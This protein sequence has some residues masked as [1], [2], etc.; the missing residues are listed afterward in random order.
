MSKNFDNLIQEIYHNEE[1]APDVMGNIYEKRTAWYVF[2]NR[3]FIQRYKL[4]GAALLLVFTAGLLWFV[5]SPSQK[6]VEMTVTPIQVES[7]PSD[8]TAGIV[9][10][11]AEA[12]DNMKEKSNDQAVDPV[13]AEDH[14]RPNTPSNSP[15]E[16]EAPIQVDD[17]SVSDVMRR[18][19]QRMRD[20][21]SDGANSM[22]NSNLGSAG[23]GKSAGDG[24]GDKQADK[25]E[26]IATNP[27]TPVDL[28]DTKLTNDPP[29]EDDERQIVTADEADKK[30]NEPAETKKDQE[31]Q[32]NNDQILPEH[33]PIRKWSLS[34]G[35]G[36]SSA[37]RKLDQN[38][39]ME[40]ANLRDRSESKF[41]SHEAFINFNLE[42]GQHVELYTGI[43]YLNRRER[44]EFT[45]VENYTIRNITENEV[46]AVHPLLPPRTFI[47]F[48]T[49]YTQIS[50][51]KNLQSTN[52]YT[53]YTLP[54]GLRYTWYQ[55]K[56]GV[57]ASADA[58]IQL[59]AQNNG[60]ILTV[61][62]VEQDLSSSDFNRRKK[63][64]AT[65]GGSFGVSY[66]FDERIT[67]LIGWKGT[68][69]LT[70]VNGS[71][72]LLDQRDYSSSLMVGVKYHF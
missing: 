28:E 58:A 16:Y 71:R 40:L 7:S 50:T 38:Q 62:A 54:I 64:G 5:W 46:V 3:L 51:S 31:D 23:D 22:G 30:A 60:S 55:N 39:N 47:L 6:E 1:S 36:A 11:D 49:S 37:Y 10:N 69:F 63:L 42:L 72:Y 53:Y 44:M 9:K 13:A 25:V 70:P 32:L 14:I 17:I 56:L 43:N 27:A 52:T 65:A 4:S 57:Y 8:N 18:R 45:S 2:R 26:E 21:H 68:Y 59:A 19:I 48:D 61:G 20:S 41:Y 24:E 29:V 12:L 67:G 33:P 66:L 35:Y 34:A 15:Q